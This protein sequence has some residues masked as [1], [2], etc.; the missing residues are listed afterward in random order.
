[1]LSPDRHLR[2]LGSTPASLSPGELGIAVSANCEEP[3]F[4]NRNLL[5]PTHGVSLIGRPT[6]RHMQSAVAQG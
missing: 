4:S 5:H 3:R 1:M 2:N 6:S